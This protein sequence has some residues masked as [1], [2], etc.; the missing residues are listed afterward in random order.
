MGALASHK[1]L[2]RAIT[3]KAH[4][5]DSPASCA[6]ANAGQSYD[7]AHHDNDA[8]PPHDLALGPRRL[9]LLALRREVAPMTAPEEPRHCKCGNTNVRVWFRRATGHWFVECNKAPQFCSVVRHGPHDTRAEAVARWNK[10][11]E[12]K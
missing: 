4:A 3:N 9:R 7:R 2:P 11:Q 12:T 8:L 6:V 1:R 5:Q 10:R